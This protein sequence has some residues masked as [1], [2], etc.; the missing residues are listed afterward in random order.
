MEDF[1][2]FKWDQKLSFVR[3]EEELTPG[4]RFRLVEIAHETK[5]ADIRRAALALVMRPVLW[6]A[7]DSN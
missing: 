3:V 1:V 2:P 5:D 4:Q 6:K 7:E